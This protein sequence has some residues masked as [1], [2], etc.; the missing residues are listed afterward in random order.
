MPKNVLDPQSKSYVP[1]SSDLAPTTHGAMAAVLHP[2]S[3]V[4]AA[5][6]DSS[7]LVSATRDGYR[8]TESLAGAGGSTL[9]S[10]G[11]P[12]AAARSVSYPAVF[13]GV[14]LSYHLDGASLADELTLAAAPSSAQKWTWHLSAPGLVAKANDAGDME[15]IDPKGM[16]VF[17]VPLPSMWDSSAVEGVRDSAYGKVGAT[18]SVTKD[19]ADVVIE[20]DQAWL[21]DPSRVYPVVVDPTLN[22]GGTAFHAYRSDGA[23]RSDAVLTGN[24]RAGGDTYWRTVMTYSYAAAA[25]AQ[26]T[27]AYVAAQYGGEGTTTT[28]QPAYM[29]YAGCFA[30]SFCSGG[31]VA[32][33]TIPLGTGSGTYAYTYGDSSDPYHVAKFYDGRLSVGDTS[34]YMAWFGNEVPGSYTYKLLATSLAIGYDQIPNVSGWSP[35]TPISGTTGITLTPTLVATTSDAEGDATGMRFTIWDNA[36]MTGTPVFQSGW[37]GKSQQIPQ[38]YLHPGTHYWYMGYVHDVYDGV[39]GFAHFHTSPLYNFTTGTPAPAPADDLTATPLDGSVV[40]TTTPILHATIP[41]GASSSTKYQFQISSDNSFTSGRIV[42]SNWTTQTAGADYQWTVDAG[43]LLDGGSYV[44]RVATDDGTT[45]WASSWSHRMRVNLRLG[46]SGP[47]PFDTAG[48]V[49]VNLANGNAALSFSS[50]TI[51]TV[52]GPIGES[53]AYNSQAV[54]ANGLTGRYYDAVPTGGGTPDFTETLI[55]TKSPLLTRVDSTADQNWNTGVDP[56]NP[57]LAPTNVSPGPGVPAANYEIRWTGFVTLPAGDYFFG[58]KRGDGAG[59]TLTTDAGVATTVL[60]QWQDGNS[61]SALNIQDS[62]KPIYHMPATP[63]RIQIDTYS[64]AGPATFALF[65]ETAGGSYSSVPASAYTRTF[66]TLPA[67]WGATTAL[68]GAAGA[69]SSAQVSASAIT[70]TDSTGSIHTYTKVSS[71]GYS[72][73]AGEYGT[74]SLDAAGKVT[75]T[76]DGG[77]VYL[78]DSSGR[79]SAVASPSDARKPASP[80]PSYRVGTGQVDWIADALSTNGATPPTYSRRVVFAYAGDQWASV[81]GMGSADSPGSASACPEDDANPKVAGMLCRI[82]YPGHV[83]GSD[84]ISKV[85]YDSDGELARIL[86]PGGEATDFGYDANGRMTSMRSPLANDWLAYTGTTPSANQQVNIAYTGGRVAS[87]TMPASDGVTASLRAAKTYSYSLNG[88]GQ[89]VGPTYVDVAGL[90]PP[91]VAPANGHA[92]TVTFDAGYRQLTSRSATGVVSTQTWSEK[93]QVLTATDAAGREATTIYDPFTGR[94]TD[95]YGPAPTACFNGTGHPQSC[96]SPVPPAHSVTHYDES[97]SGL[98]VAWFNNATRSGLPV[99]YSLGYP[100]STSG[101]VNSNWGTSAPA[102]ISGITST[103]NFSSRGTGYITFPTSAGNYTFEV[104][105]DD[106]AWLWVDDKQI[107]QVTTPGTSGPS[108]TVTTTATNQKLR[109]RLES[110]ETTGTASLGLLWKKPGDTSYTTVPGTQLTPDYGLVTSTV[111]EDSVPSGMSSSQVP[112]TTSTATNYVYPW[113]GEASQTSLDP[114]GLNLRSQVSYEAGSGGYLRPLSQLMPSQVASGASLGSAAASNNVYWGDSAP[115]SSRLTTAPCP[116]VT[117]STPQ[118]GLLWST[119]T[120]APASI[121]TDYVYDL[122]GRAVGTKRTGDTGWTCATY[123][124]RWRP[125]TVSFP[126]Y[127]AG[128]ARTVT[129]KYTSDGT[130]TGDPLTTSISDPA[131]PIT[132]VHDFLGRS[133]TYTDVWGTVTTS[134]YEATTGRLSQSSVVTPGMAAKAEQFVYDSDGRVTQISDNGN[135]VSV[136]SYDSI[137]GELTGE[138]HPTGTGYAGEGDALS[139]IVH[140]ANTGALNSETWSLA[141]RPT[142]T[143]TVTRSQTG[144]VLQDVLTKISSPTVVYTSAY[145][146][147]AAGRLAQATV[148]HHVLSYNFAATSSCGANTHAGQDGNRTSMTDVKDG[149]TPFTT[150]YC[151][152]NADRLTSSTV[153]NPPAGADQVNSGLA[154]TG[155]AYDGHGNATTFADESIGYDSADEHLTTTIPGET[156]SYLRDA[157]GRI[158]QRIVSPVSGS[159]E[160]ER[161]TYAGDGD[162]SWGVLSATNVRIQRTMVFPAGD[163]VITDSIGNRFWYF[164]DI[165]GDTIRSWKTSTILQLFDP[166]GQPLNFTTGELGTT[167]GDDNV[168]DNSPG[169]MDVGAFGAAMR[170]YEHEGDIATTEMGARQYVAALGRFLEVDPVAGG[171]AN[172]YNYPNDPIDGRDLTGLNLDHGYGAPAPSSAHWVSESNKAQLAKLLKAPKKKVGQAIEEIKQTNRWIRSNSNAY[173]TDVDVDITSGNVRLRASGELLDGNVYE[174]MGMDDFAAAVQ[175]QIMKDLLKNWLDSKPNGTLNPSVD[176]GESPDRIIGELGVVDGDE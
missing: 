107:I 27:G 77:T 116:G 65:Y 85:L 26:V 111:T 46:T 91:T 14:D 158:V 105:A 118:S 102:L 97:M 22:P 125:A 168:Y 140:D 58:V 69:Y 128:A 175:E 19:G 16:V 37:S 64:K 39:W 25:G 57:Q 70:L 150:S 66:Q 120:P 6:S 96:S 34:P 13:P 127:G 56:A 45:Q 104:S 78:F 68:A 33:M 108:I 156:V 47:S 137:T 146:Y 131:G 122:Y 161:Y 117:T 75:F 20:P 109:I 12:R 145:S 32:A 53:F 134:T 110:S 71:G 89:S 166:F 84:D 135:I 132:T 17:S 133:K 101:A 164:S 151:Y 74:M 170:P 82:I 169:A 63:V 23:F 2:L 113:L 18:W 9:K 98:N 67:G 163:Y 115:L 103:D 43:V 106:A 50:P 80:V 44:W 62:G 100:G 130:P 54:S 123:D 99:D 40:T 121:E 141:T 176:E 149:G 73:P 76:D 138:T 4:F 147:D 79:V 95:S 83:A 90:T 126:A 21:T 148:P 42:Y 36:A 38:G 129:A 174:S 86:D 11:S 142:F 8:L 124:P 15:F 139:N 30:Y 49:T 87:V 119:T 143:D 167:T 52:G 154:S 153:T 136:D 55:D 144:R 72:P 92:G 60:Y 61:D 51:N 93:D 160:V 10:D 159:P 35:P 1:M 24:S 48:P 31:N 112:G 5:T 114:S 88:A 162:S 59:V 94:A 157:T 28:A 173:N 171:N 152:D 155:L 172:A 29:A 3:P 165:H 41:S 7:S 81:A